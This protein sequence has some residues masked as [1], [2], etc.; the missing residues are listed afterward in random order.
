M[1]RRGKL[2]TGAVRDGLARQ[3]WHDVVR[4]GASRIGEHGHDGIAVAG[5]ARSGQAR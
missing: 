3:E 2:R 1:V 4:L 5:W